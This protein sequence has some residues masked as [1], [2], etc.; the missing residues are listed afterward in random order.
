MDAK[1]LSYA[2]LLTTGLVLL[3][4]IPAALILLKEILAIVTIVLGIMARKK[5]DKHGGLLI[6]VVGIY[7]VVMTLVWDYIAYILQSV[8]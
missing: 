4:I 6:L 1:H 8:A 7:L 2:G 3:P 5:G